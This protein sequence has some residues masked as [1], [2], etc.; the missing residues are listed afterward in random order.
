LYQI[1]FVTL[2]YMWTEYID[3]PCQMVLN[4]ALPD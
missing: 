1:S 4:L 2:S 3:S